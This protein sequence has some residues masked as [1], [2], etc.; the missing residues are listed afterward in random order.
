MHK[1]SLGGGG[2]GGPHYGNCK[3]RIGAV[4]FQ[5]KVGFF[6]ISPPPFHMSFP[7][8]LKSNS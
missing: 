5:I 3:V 2:G 6:A 1:I 8:V 4:L 7:L